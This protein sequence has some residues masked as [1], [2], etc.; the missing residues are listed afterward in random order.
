MSL[1]F[2]STALW[3]QSINF[4]RLMKVRLVGFFI[5][6]KMKKFE[7]RWLINITW[8]GVNKLS[9]KILSKSL[10]LRRAVFS[11]SHCW[12]QPMMTT[13]TMMMICWKNFGLFQW[14]VL[15]GSLG[16]RW[17]FW[18]VVQFKSCGALRRTLRSRNHLVVLLGFCS[19]KNTTSLVLF[20]KIISL[21]TVQL[22]SHIF[23]NIYIFSFFCN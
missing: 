5:S 15:I 2:H 12:R 8:I 3:F 7:N 6:S 20:F 11:S 14:E 22:L 4:F 19:I 1:I 16:Y 18:I 13:T 21:C 23:F 10:L 17:K 9:Q